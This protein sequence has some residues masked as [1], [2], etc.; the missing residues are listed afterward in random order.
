MFFLRENRKYRQ[1]KKIIEEQKE[2]TLQIQGDPIKPT[3]RHNYVKFW[4]I[5]DRE[6][7]LKLP[8][9]KIKLGHHN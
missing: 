4:N 5:K 3:L 8:R 7:T 1:R 9:E 6:K 2:L